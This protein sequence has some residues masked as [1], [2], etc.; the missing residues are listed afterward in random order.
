MPVL[1][2][3]AN[4]KQKNE[5]HYVVYTYRHTFAHRYLTGFY[6]RP[7]GTPIVLN[8]GEVAELMGNSATEV[9][10]TYGKLVK[11]TT[12]LSSLAKHA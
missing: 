12:Y 9:E 2:K 1:V 6:T 5:Y 3:I 4:G 10:R 11:A 7:D 8:Y